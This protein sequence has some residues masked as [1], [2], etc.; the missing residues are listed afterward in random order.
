MANRKAQTLARSLGFAC[1]CISAKALPWVAAHAGVTL[2]TFFLTLHI[3][4]V[5]M[6]TL[7]TFSPLTSIT[8]LV[9][10]TSR[11]D[12]LLSSQLDSPH[13]ALP[14]P[15]VPISQLEGFFKMQS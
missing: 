13:P 3:P 7:S 11:L 15:N 4:S 6:A 8:I 12:H 1:S 10:V 2:D 14:S 9:Q 5:I